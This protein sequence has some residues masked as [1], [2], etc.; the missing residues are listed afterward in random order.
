MVKQ[1][2]E[3][4]LQIEIRNSKALANL[5]MGLSSESTLSSAI[6]I[7]LSP[8]YHYQHTSISK[9]VTGLN[10]RLKKTLK[11]DSLEIDQSRLLTPLEME[12][13]FTY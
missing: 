7:S 3:S 1:F 10:I 5:V 9:V 11:K 4:I 2:C 13:K 8:C 12:K 6:A